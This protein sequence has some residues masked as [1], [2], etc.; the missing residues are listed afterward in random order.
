[1]S[2]D[3]RARHLLARLDEMALLPLRRLLGGLDAESRLVL[4]ALVAAAAAAGF[5]LGRRRIGNRAGLRTL[6]ALRRVGFQNRGEA[7][8][9]R[10]LLANF[11]APDYHLLNHVT[12]RTRDGSTQI[13]HILLSRFGVFVIET[14]DYNG[15]IFATTMDATWTHVYFRRRFTRQNP[16]LQNYKHVRAVE[17]LLDFLP[18]D[19]FKSVVVFTGSASFG[20]SVPTGVVTLEELPDFVRQHQQAVMSAKMLQFCVGR[21]EM[22][23]LAISRETDVDHVQHLARRFGHDD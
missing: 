4:V 1:M 3:E 8:V 20:T 13:D 2:V 11:G 6:G 10:V 7:M 21:L 14:K 15:L 19:A 12:L 17:D 18:H 9:S 5:L 16:L 22:A 23:R